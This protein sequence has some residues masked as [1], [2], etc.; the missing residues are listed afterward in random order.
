MM[1]QGIDVDL[2]DTTT[3]QLRIRDEPLVNIIG[4]PKD[5][6]LQVKGALEAEDHVLLADILQYEFTDV[7]E[8]WHALISMLRHEAEERLQE[9]PSS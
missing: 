5:T 8:R 6:L 2:P 7:T 9:T 3:Q 1:Q 4:M